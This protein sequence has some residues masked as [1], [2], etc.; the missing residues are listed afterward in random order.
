MLA[1]I[2]QKNEQERLLAD[3]RLNLQK[4]IDERT[5]ALSESEARYRNIF[6]NIQDVYYETG[7]DGTIARSVPASRFSP[8]ANT[9]ART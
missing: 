8:A 7:L 6:E 9:R 3:E 2:L 4:R 5:A 1:T